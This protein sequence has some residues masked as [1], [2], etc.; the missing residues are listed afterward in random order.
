MVTK[1]VIITIR[2]LDI[3]VDPSPSD[4]IFCF[5][6]SLC[7]QL[8]NFEGTIIFFRL[9]IFEPCTPVYLSS[10]FL[11]CQSCG[12]LAPHQT[13]SVA[14]FL[15]PVL[16]FHNINLFAVGGMFYMFC[17]YL[18][19]ARCLLRYCEILGDLFSTNPSAAVIYRKLEVLERMLNDYGRGLLIPAAMTVVPV[20]EITSMLAIIKLHGE[21]SF[22]GFLIF[23]LTFLVTFT[24]LC[25][26]ETVSGRLRMASTN[27][28]W[29]WSRRCDIGDCKYR[30][31]NMRSMQPLTV[32]FA[33][34]FIDRETALV[35]QNFCLNQI[36]S[37][38][39]M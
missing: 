34:N 17:I 5:L 26:L 19:S 30:R 11:D 14:R 9:L 32:R 20:I 8:R 24:G 1:W 25:L 13:W 10:I 37:L 4:K 21:I 12:V 23:P 35:T 15:F 31:R 33:S 18:T 28:L 39:M 36:V 22:P 38:L 6:L 29:H 16:D 2:Y 3:K 7:T 27:L